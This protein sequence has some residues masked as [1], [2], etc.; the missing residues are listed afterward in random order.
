MGMG[1]V[2]QK[3]VMLLDIDRVLSTDQA[4]ILDEAQA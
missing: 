4:A 2:A 1:K 3:V